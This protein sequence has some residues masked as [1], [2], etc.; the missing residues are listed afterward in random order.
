MAEDAADHLLSCQRPSRLDNGPL[1]M[2]PLWFDGIQ[3]GAFHRQVAGQ[4]PDSSVP[5]Y[6]LIMHMNPGTYFAAGVPERVVPD[7]H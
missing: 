1:A 6:G 7:Q 2:D 4:E 5:P 3:L